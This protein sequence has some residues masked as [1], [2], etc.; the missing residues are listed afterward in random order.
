MVRY[1]P[2]ICWILYDSSDWMSEN[3][4]HKLLELIRKCGKGYSEY[5]NAFASGNGENLLKVAMVPSI[6]H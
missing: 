1:N 6:Y 2:V 5:K 3:F 4:T